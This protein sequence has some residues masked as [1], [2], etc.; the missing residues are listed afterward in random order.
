MSQ[1]VFWPDYTHSILGIPNTILNY[2]GI[3]TSYT[4]LPILKKSLRHK[5]KNVVLWI[6]DGLG[7]DLIQQALP[8][9]AFLRRHI[10]D[11]LSS[12]F[13]PTTTAATTTYYSALPP[14][15]HGWVGW[16]PYFANQNR[17]IEL[18]TGRDS[19]TGE[20]TQI[21]GEKEL[22]YTHIF[23]QILQG[24]TSVTCTEI[25]PQKIRQTGAVT[26]TE[27]CA[28]IRKQTRQPGQQFILAYWPEPDHTCHH[29]GTYSPESLSLIKQINLAI[30]NLCASLSDTT[31]IISADH[32]HTPI[33]KIIYINDY[34]DFTDCLAVPLNMDDRVYSV[35][36]KPN[37]EQ[38]LVDSFHRYFSDD[39]M[40]IKSDIARQKG[41]FGPGKQ[42]PKITEFLGDYLIIAT[43][44]K[45][46]RHRVL[47]GVSGPEFLSSHAGLTAKEMIVPLMII[48]K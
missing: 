25:F 16:S 10:V 1:S 42:H 38:Q 20:Q 22:P 18:F 13:P 7:L 6:L 24:K 48:S 37:K 36:L 29:T 32:G 35:F 39:F 28:R 17:Y 3:P 4:A 27:Q 2:Y 21:T 8:K 19:F 30:R 12:V 31:V 9:N 44:D 33:K 41:L 45:V 46:L 34:P 47:E 40:L 5:P 23:K 15:C 11:S 26:F 14:V 43:A